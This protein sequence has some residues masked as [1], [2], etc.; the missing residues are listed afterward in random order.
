MKRTVL[1]TLVI[2]ALPLFL[3]LA[4]DVA[5]SIG[6]PSFELN[7][8]EFQLKRY[9]LVGQV[10]ELTFDRILGLKEVVPDGYVAFVTYHNANRIEGLKII[11]PRDGL[12]FFKGQISPDSVGD[13]T[14]YIQVRT[15]DTV[16]AIGTYYT[17]ENDGV[18]YRW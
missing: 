3:T 9:D 15:P 1:I 13:K 11:V 7:V 2:T 10:G 17:E 16:K 8:N 18:H 5:S 12:D 14:I 4:Q 6:K